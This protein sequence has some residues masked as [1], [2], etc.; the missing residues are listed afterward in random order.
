MQ[1]IQFVHHVVIPPGGRHVRELHVHPDAEELI[2]V[3]EGIGRLTIG[4]ETSDVEAGDVGYVPPNAEHIL[5]NTGAKMLRAL[6]VNVPVGEA[7][8]TLATPA[9]DDA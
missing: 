3:M 5:T 9:G 2:V 4:E 7:L 1:T 6:F 8:A